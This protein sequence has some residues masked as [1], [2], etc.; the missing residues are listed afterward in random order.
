MLRKKALVLGAQTA[1]SWGWT[2]EG[3]DGPHATIRYE[4]D[5]RD[6]DNALAS[7]ALPEVKLVTTKPNYGGRRWWFICPIVRRDGG[8]P[9]QRS[10]SCKQY[11]KLQPSVLG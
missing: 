8:P 3:E 4:A 7:A 6:T 9:P 11:G 10:I 5:L 1:G 2:Y